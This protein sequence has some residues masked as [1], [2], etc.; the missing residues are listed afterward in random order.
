MNL[1]FRIKRIVGGLTQP[2]QSTVAVSHVHAAARNDDLELALVTQYNSSWK[3]TARGSR[4]TFVRKPLIERN[5]KIMTIGSCFALE[6]RQALASIGFDV[7]PKY[8]DIQFDPKSQKLAK[9]P[10]RDDVNHYNTFTISAEFRNA[11]ARAHYES[12]DFVRAATVL[13]RSPFEVPTK[14]VWQDP[15]RKHIYAANESGIQEL[16]QKVDNCIYDAIMNADI[17]VITLGLTEVWRKDDN[18]KIIN[19]IPDQMLKGRA[20]GFTFVRSDYQDNY[21]NI[22][23]VCSLIA[24]HFPNKKIVLTVSPVALKRTFSRN[25]IVVANMESKSTLRAVAAAIDREFDNVVY[26]PSYE[27][28]MARDIYAE[29]GRHVTLEGI[30]AIVNQFL[31][32]H[33]Q[34]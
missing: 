14:E 17:Y 26:W 11:F 24:E 5:D 3:R 30:N 28:A 7:Y 21:E 4:L 12:S 20:P 32:V 13:G 29:D 16:S 19:Q 15:Y 1:P 8:G 23:D 18:G 10:V 6:I 25:D 33:L 2:R 22:R 9:L 31:T 27:M 34:S